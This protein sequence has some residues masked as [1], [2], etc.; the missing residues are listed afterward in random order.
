M[1]LDIVEYAQLMKVSISTVRRAIKANKVKFKLQDGKYFV[2]R[3][4]T[5][6]CPVCG[7]HK[8]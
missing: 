2:F 3:E 4:A 1:W 5:N 8:L 6:K 7:T